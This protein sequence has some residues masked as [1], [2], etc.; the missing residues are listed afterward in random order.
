MFKYEFKSTTEMGYRLVSS[1]S[2]TSTT[3][4]SSIALPALHTRW[5]TFVRDFNIVNSQKFSGNYT[6]P[7][8]ITGKILQDSDAAIAYPI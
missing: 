3:T 7:S 6:R 5:L 1:S 4:T 8:H 2:T